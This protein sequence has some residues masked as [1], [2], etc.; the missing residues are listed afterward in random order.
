MR[1]TNFITESINDKGILKAVFFVGYPGAGKTTIIRKIK[2]GA[3]PVV[4]ISTDI[5]TE[6]YSNTRQTTD[7]D[8]IGGQAKHLTVVDLSNKVNGLFPVFVDT[9]GADVS[10]FRKRVEF[11]RDMGYD[12]S[13]IVVDVDFETSRERVSLRNQ[14][15][16][17]QVGIDFVRRAYDTISKSIPAF[18]SLIPDHTT[19]VNKDLSDTEVLKAYNIIM[20]KLNSPIKNDKGKKLVDYMKQMGYKY[21]QDIPVDWLTANDFPVLDKTSIQWFNK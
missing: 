19:I 16:Q 9:T 20:K 8:T 18:K 1:L 10:R 21:Y 6:F 7:W 2:D 13:L 14:S 11:L 17:R 15:Q 4:S 5:W 12:V 3:M